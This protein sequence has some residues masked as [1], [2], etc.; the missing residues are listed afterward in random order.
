MP[1]PQCLKKYSMVI[2][3]LSKKSLESI[4]ALYSTKGHLEWFNRV[5]PEA[6][7]FSPKQLMS[8]NACDVFMPLHG[9]NTKIQASVLLSAKPRELDVLLK[10]NPG[11]AKKAGNSFSKKAGNK[12]SGIPALVSTTPVSADKILLFARINRYGDDKSINKIKKFKIQLKNSN[13]EKS[14][15]TDKLEEEINDARK[16][17]QGLLPQALPRIEG[18]EFAS[19]FLPSCRTGGDLYDVFPLE[20]E[21]LGILVFDVCGHGFA[22]SYI[23]GMAKM[24]FKN[25]MYRYDDPAEVIKASNYDLESGIKTEHFV[26]A[27]FG[28]LDLKTMDLNYS[29]G[30]HIPPLHYIDNINTVNALKVSGVPLGLFPEYTYENHSVKL[31]QGDRVLFFTDGLNESFNTCME[32]F[33]L[34]RLTQ[35]LKAAAHNNA[36]GIVT[37]VE[38]ERRLFAGN[39]PNEDDIT[40]IALCVEN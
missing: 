33:G 6:T 38:T 39:C 22:A 25:N 21:R 13:T 7:G 11:P 3:A 34:V 5:L 20:K 23:A 35:V 40:I 17:Q 29:S 28:I 30:G 9:K 8:F 15:I 32:Q 16:I 4:I 24:A 12:A 31:L 19:M 26:A 36:E 10:I 37:A 27:F 14:Q 1:L 18:V 2:D